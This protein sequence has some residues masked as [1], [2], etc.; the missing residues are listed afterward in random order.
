MAR[1]MEKMWAMQAARDVV[2]SAVATFLPGFRGTIQVVVVGGPE[3]D[4]RR[5]WYLACAA[6]FGRFR[7]CP[8]A[9]FQQMEVASTWDISNKAVTIELSYKTNALSDTIADN[10]GPVIA[11]AAGFT[12]L[13]LVAKGAMMLGGVAIGEA[14][15]AKISAAGSPSGAQDAWTYLHRGPEQITVGEN[16][17]LWARGPRQQTGADGAGS[18]QSVWTVSRVLPVTGARV[19]VSPLGWRSTLAA[20]REFPVMQ[21]ELVTR[22]PFSCQTTTADTSGLLITG[23]ENTTLFADVTGGAT[24]TLPDAGRIITTVEKRINRIT[25]PLPPLDGW[26]RGSLVELVAQALE[27]PCVWPTAPTGISQNYIA[28]AG[29]RVFVGTNAHSLGQIA[30]AAQ[31]TLLGGSGSVVGPIGP[32]GTGPRTEGNDV[33]RMPTSVYSFSE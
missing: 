31:S 7:N 33:E 23:N 2:G 27:Q 17:P 26:S 21:G 9:A 6:A 22:Y 14:L 30:T 3:A 5:C 28:S 1:M 10:I 4:M 25:P 20:M 18:G 24:P 29:V 16:W 11:I 15:K 13:G 8:S 32:I 19:A 12:P